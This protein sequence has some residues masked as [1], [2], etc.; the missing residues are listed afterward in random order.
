MTLK[1][2]VEKIGDLEQIRRTTKPDLYK[3]LL[4]LKTED[5][6][7]LYPEIRNSLL[8]LIDREGIVEGCLVE[9]EYR[10]QGSEKNDKVYNNI[11]LQSIRRI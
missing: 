1:A 11:V 8:K 4:T 6:Q 10:F 3:Q 2:Q 9:V 7:I 5:G